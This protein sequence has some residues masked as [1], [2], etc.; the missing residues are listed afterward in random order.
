MKTKLKKLNPGND[1][2]FFTS[3]PSSSSSKLDNVK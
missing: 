3:V 2:K 1:D